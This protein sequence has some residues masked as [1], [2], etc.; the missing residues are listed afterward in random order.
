MIFLILIEND[1]RCV[2]CA[3]VTALSA[4]VVAVRM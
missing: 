4:S 2:R 1:V 3:K